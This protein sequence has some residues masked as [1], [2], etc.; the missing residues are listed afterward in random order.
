LCDVGAFEVQPYPGAQ[1]QVGMTL[2]F[3]GVCLVLVRWIFKT[4]YRLRD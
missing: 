2:L 1:R 3:L 4:G